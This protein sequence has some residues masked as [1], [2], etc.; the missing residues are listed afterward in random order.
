MRD[1]RERLRDILDAVAAVQK[2]VPLGR[3]RFDQD[4]LVQTWILH[5]LQVIGEAAAVLPADMRRRCPSIPWPEIVGMRNIL[6]H[7]YYEVDLDVVW[8]VAHDDLPALEQEVETLL[9][10]LDRPAEPE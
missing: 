7:L 1:P 2:Y 5:H 10:E 8:R 6:V 3:E 4:E 9:D